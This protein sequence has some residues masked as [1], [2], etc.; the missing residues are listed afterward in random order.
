MGTPTVKI[1]NLAIMKAS[2]RGPAVTNPF[3]S[4]AADTSLLDWKTVKE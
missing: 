2:P 4:T 3:S 1:L